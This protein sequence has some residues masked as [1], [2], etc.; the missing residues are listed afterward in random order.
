MIILK[1][2][3]SMVGKNNQQRNEQTLMQLDQV[4]CE[5][6]KLTKAELVI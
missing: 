2:V 4:S 5:S 3:L 1:I 6:K